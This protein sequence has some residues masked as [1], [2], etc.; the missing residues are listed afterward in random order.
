MLVLSCS[1]A[2]LALFPLGLQVKSL[3]WEKNR[4]LRLERR[5]LY[6]R[7]LVEHSLAGHGP[8]ARDGAYAGGDG[9]SFSL[10]SLGIRTYTVRTGD[11]LFAISRR[12]NVSIDTLISA[13]NITNA[14]YLQVGKTLSI[15]SASGIYHTVRSGENLSVIAGRFGVGINDIA[16][17][18]DLA[19]SVLQVGQRLFIPGGA[20]SDWERALALGELFIKPVAGR[21]TSRMGFRLDPFTRMRAYH[22]G[23]DIAAKTGTPV[24]AAQQGRVTFA[25]YRGNY[26]K[27]VILSHPDGYST[28]YAHLDRISVKRG[29]AVGRGRQV[30]TVGNTGRS[31]GP[32]LHFEVHQY[33]KL[34]DP[35]KLI[36]W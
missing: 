21:I 25:G 22:A 14:Y 7:L 29:Q 35:L 11:S 8:E 9:A 13:N 27:T 32:H 3:L 30:G 2:L 1:A 20:L 34:L 12:F 17:I 15:P 24:A 4:N 28:L 18:N 16:D 33:R 26:G 10:P 6:E 5:V 19:S 31:T 36:H 23:I